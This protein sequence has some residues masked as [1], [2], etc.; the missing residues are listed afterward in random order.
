MIINTVNKL[1]VSLYEPRIPQNTGNIGRTCAAFNISLDLIQPLGFSIESKHMKR[2]GLD[3]WKF[4]DIKVHKDYNSYKEYVC[5]HRI[6]GFS[7]KGGVP[8][9]T[10]KF[11]S[12]DILLF[13]REDLGLPQNIQNDCDIMS[14]IQMPGIADEFGRNGVRSLNLSSACAIAAYYSLINFGD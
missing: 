13:G 6:I 9:N 8:L 10:L 1:R 4:I 3:Y 11:K 12:K 2:A 7:K 14:T 5:G